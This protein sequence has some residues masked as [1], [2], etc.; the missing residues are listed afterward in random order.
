MKIYTILIFLLLSVSLCAQQHNT[1]GKPDSVDLIRGR[2][3]IG[4]ILI[5][6]MTVPKKEAN[7][8]QK[9]LCGALDVPYTRNRKQREEALSKRVVAII[10]Q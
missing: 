5:Y 8:L 3:V 9:Y 1:I 7:A 6:S 2:I 4:D 10:A